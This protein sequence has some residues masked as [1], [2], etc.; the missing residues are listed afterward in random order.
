M[1]YQGNVVEKVGNVIGL[2]LEANNE[3]R[4]VRIALND[5]SKNWKVGDK[6]KFEGYLKEQN[7]VIIPTRELGRIA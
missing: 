6:V 5:V 4:M 1:Q 3:E 7:L 2:E